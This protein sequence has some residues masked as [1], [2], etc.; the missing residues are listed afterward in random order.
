MRY[1]H[2]RFDIWFCLGLSFLIGFIPVK[3]TQIILKHNYP[4][5]VKQH[6]VSSKEIG[7]IPDNSM[8][9]AQNIED[10]LSHDTFTIVS[11]GIEYRNK[12]GGYHNNYYMHAVTLPSGEKVAALINEEN[13]KHIGDSIYSGDSILPLGKVV[14]EDLTQDKSFIHQIEYKEKLTRTDFYIDMLG[15][16]GKVSEHDYVRAPSTIVQLLTIILLFPLFHMI[17]AKIGIFP[18]FFAPKNQKKSEWK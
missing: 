9:Q 13:V 4:S 8:Y 18:Y 2:L 12:G 16:G 5:Y 11:P 1:H 15:N 7:G 10:L 14:Y 6:T 17:G 3:I